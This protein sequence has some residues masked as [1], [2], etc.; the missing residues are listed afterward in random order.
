MSMTSNDLRVYRTRKYLKKAFISLLEEQE[1]YKISVQALTKKAEINRVTY[2]LHYQDM[3]DFIEQFLQD[4]L[5]EIET[6]LMA[7]YDAP[8]E[9]DYEL[10]IL[11]T[12]LEYISANSHIYKTLMVSKSIPYFTP[13]LIELMQ[14]M[15]LQ[16]E[17]HTSPAFQGSDIPKDIAA[18]YGTSA[19]VGTIA[20]WLG[21]DMPY[22]PH[23]LAKQMV[24]LNPFFPK[25]R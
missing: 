2:Y 1:F 9:P 19:M 21:E 25:I 6:I 24:K 13:R 8:E 7:K 23:Y 15:I 12:F 10:N 17:T 18:W 4:L 20:L 5:D 16:D 14:K 11:V 22:S 3:D